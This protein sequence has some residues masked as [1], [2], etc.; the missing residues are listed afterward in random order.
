MQSSKMTE[1]APEQGVQINQT[2]TSQVRKDALR[3]DHAGIAASSPSYSKGRTAAAPS[4][5]NQPISDGSS[6]PFGQTRFASL[7]DSS[8]AWTPTSQ[9]L[10]EALV[11]R[12]KTAPV[13]ETFAAMDAETGDGSARWVL[14]DSH[15]AEAGFQDPA[16]GWISVRA[17]AG[18]TGIHAAVMPSSDTAA[19]VLSSHLAG[20]NAHMANQYEHMNAVTLSVPGSDWNGQSTG[21][22]LAQGNHRGSNQENQQ[23]T[24]QNSE[25]MPS[26]PVRHFTNDIQ[27]ER[28]SVEAPVFTRTMSL[29]E[30]H[31]SIVV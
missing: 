2:S 12:G 17:H 7:P 3:R 23:Q 15:R 30:R 4:N 20:L 8:A 18:A 22:E 25:P 16:L 9:E 21:R 19:E 13:H 31:F 1:I 6:T 27:D 10:D 29:N 14:A 28:M 11:P 26:E 5:P 24:Q